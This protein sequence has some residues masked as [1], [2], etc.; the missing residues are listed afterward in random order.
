MLPA[1]L[2]R[3]NISCTQHIW[4]L[5]AGWK[6]M[7]VGRPNGVLSPLCSSMDPDPLLTTVQ[8]SEITDIHLDPD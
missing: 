3:D 4:R 5:P 7:Y 6:K 2:L 8:C 1:D